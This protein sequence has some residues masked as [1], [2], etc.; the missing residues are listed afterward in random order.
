MSSIPIRCDN[1]SALNLT[2]NTVMHSRIEHIDIRQ[3]FFRD[4]VL[5]GDVEVT[6]VDTCTC[7]STIFDIRVNMYSSYLENALKGCIYSPLWA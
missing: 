2:K 7:K 5:K 6:F 3:V 1:T 4:H